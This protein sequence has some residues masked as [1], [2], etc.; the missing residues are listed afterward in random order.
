MSRLRLYLYLKKQTLTITCSSQAEV[1]KG[2][3]EML[4]SVCLYID[5]VGAVSHRHGIGPVPSSDF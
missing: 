5:C 4:L 2:T 1:I 3:D